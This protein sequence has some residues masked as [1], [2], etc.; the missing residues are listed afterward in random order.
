ML[1]MKTISVARN[2]FASR[3]AA[4]QRG[5]FLHPYGDQPDPGIV[6]GL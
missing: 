5:L 3:A 4:L 6:L 2:Q 1:E